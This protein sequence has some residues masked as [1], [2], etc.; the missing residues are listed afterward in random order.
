MDAKIPISTV[1]GAVDLSATF[2]EMYE[3]ASDIVE[4]KVL[5][6]DSVIV[7]HDTPF[8]NTFVEIKNVLKG[9]LNE[10]DVIMTTELGGVYYPL[11]F[12]DESLGKSKTPVEIAFEG[13]RVLQPGEKTILFISKNPNANSSLDSYYVHGVNQGK[14]KINGNKFEINDHD[15]SKFKFDTVDKLKEE[16]KKLKDKNKDR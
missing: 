2:N 13:I 5:E 16:V 8:T 6:H 12:G 15:H 9:D 7:E 3:I 10:K 4:V 11:L 1:K 14:Y